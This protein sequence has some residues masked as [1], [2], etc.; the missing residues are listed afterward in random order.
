MILKLPTIGDKIY[1][2]SAYHISNGQDD[3]DGGLTTI[4]HIKIND[5]LPDDHYNK[6]M[7]RVKEVPNHSYNY[8]HLMENQEKW[9]KEY[10][11]Q[12]A[13]P[14]PDINT[15]WIEDGDI[16]DGAVYHGGDIW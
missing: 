9:S 4:S 6:I 15:P 14:N 13:M 1:I 8:R 12:I 16:V 2:E 10:A 11:G 7:V 5:N 3:V